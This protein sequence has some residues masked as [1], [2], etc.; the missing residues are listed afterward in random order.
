VGGLDADNHIFVFGGEFGD[1]VGIEVVLFGGVGD[2]AEAGDVD[3]GVGPDELAALLELRELVADL[4]QPDRGIGLSKLATQT[5]IHQAILSESYNGVYAGRPDEIAERIRAFF[6]RLEQQERYGGLRAFVDTQLAGALWTVF[7]KVRVTRKI[8]IV[9]G[10]EQMGKSRA[11]EE[12]TERNNSGRTIHLELPG[13]TISGLG[14]F[15]ND[16]ADY[17]GIATTIKQADKRLR[18]KHALESCDLLIIDEAHVMSRWTDRAQADW[19][20]YVRTDLYANGKRGIT[21]IAESASLL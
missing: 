14:L 19:W 7:D 2:H 10:P 9:E 17:V 4:L 20:D 1:G 12:Y 6:H 5:R 21:S 13:G 15:I 18:I 16:L 3:D 11:S 8:Q